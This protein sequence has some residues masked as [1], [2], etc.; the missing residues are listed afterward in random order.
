MQDYFLTFPFNK[1]KNAEIPEIE[2]EGTSRIIILNSLF[3]KIL[4]LLSF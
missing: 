4:I 1:S 3:D 2:N